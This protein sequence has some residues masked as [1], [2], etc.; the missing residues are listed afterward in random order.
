MKNGLLVF[1][2]MLL[3]MASAF[4][5]GGVAHDVNIF[6]IS[7][8]ASGSYW[9][10]EAHT[11]DFNI[12]AYDANGNA[13]GFDINCYVA[14]SI[15]AKDYNFPIRNDTNLFWQL[16]GGSYCT[17]NNDF[18]KPAA[19][20]ICRIPFT[21]TPT[22]H[23][24]GDGNYYVDVNCWTT[25]TAGALSGDE[26]NTTSS[27]VFAIDGNAPLGGPDSFVV[28]QL[29]GT[30]V[31]FYWDVNT[32]L[33]ANPR[34]YNAFMFYYST[35]EFTNCESGTLYGQDTTYNLTSKDLT[36][37]TTN[38]DYYFCVAKQD[39]AGNINGTTA[40]ISA[41]HLSRDTVMGG[42]TA[43]G[44]QI[45]TTTTEGG[46]QAGTVT[47]QAG[48]VGNFFTKPLFS[49]GGFTITG[50]LLLVLLLGYYFLVVKKKKRK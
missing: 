45:V 41:L 40:R 30:S 25:D 37:L 27:A 4:A 39:Q 22:T 46:A 48:M 50:G 42:T 7:A 17:D 15:A 29:T 16:Q 1:G 49:L 34:D 12:H 11:I 43:A 44:G 35:T 20:N 2:A 21:L 8:P 23:H 47:T 5:A 26:N 13:G 33:A 6:S 31:R 32:S 38:T 18:N 19:G 3:I 36:G 28:Q 14:V 9:D 10:N 24:R